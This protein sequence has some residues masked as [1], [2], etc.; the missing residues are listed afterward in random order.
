MLEKV[1]EYIQKSLK[2]NSVHYMKFHDFATSVA[3]LIDVSMEAAAKAHVTG[4]PPALR[5]LK[6]EMG[7]EL[8]RKTYVIIPTVWPVS[9]YKIRL[10]MFRKLM[11]FNQIKQQVLIVEGVRTEEDARSTLGRIV[12]DR[13]LALLVFGGPDGKRIR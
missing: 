1:D 5:R 6:E 13:A 9:L 11:D 7:D 8:W 3:P 2:S 4:T 10:Q 12:A